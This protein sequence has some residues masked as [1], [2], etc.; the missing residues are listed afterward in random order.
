MRRADECSK[1][2]G[3]VVKVY[4]YLR[5]SLAF[6]NAGARG[7]ALYARMRRTSFDDITGLFRRTSRYSYR[8]RKHHYCFLI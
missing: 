4:L 3:L 7:N 8:R 6:Y 1:A 5:E 2:L